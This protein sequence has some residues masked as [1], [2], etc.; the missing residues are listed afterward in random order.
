MEIPVLIETVNNNGY[1]ARSGEPLPLCAEGAS[2]SEALK[3]LRQMM[4]SRLQNGT[5]MTTLKIG[6][7]NP[8]EKMD[9][10]FEEEP[11]F[12]EW[13]KAIE[14]YRQQVEEDHDRR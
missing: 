6:T 2:P 12:D 8:W 11:L 10:V 4:D 7:E 13:Q 5:Q 14:N 1:R 9:G 3:N